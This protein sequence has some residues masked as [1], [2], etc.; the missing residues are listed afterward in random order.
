MSDLIIALLGG[1]A[2]GYLQGKQSFKGWEGFVSK[3]SERLQQLAYNKVFRPVGLYDKVNESAQLYYEAIV[4]YLVGLP[5]ACLPLIFRCLEIGLQKHYEEIE[6]KKCSLN[7]SQL[8]EWSAE[9]LKDKRE[10]AH[11]FR[12][13]RNLIHKEGLIEEQDALE[14]I[15]HITQILNVVFPVR[16]PSEFITGYCPF[17]QHSFVELAERSYCFLGNT[18][19]LQCS[20]CGKNFTQALLPP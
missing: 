1:A 13:L 4:A 15:R 10:V 6:R 14:G 7:S 20:S 11:A 9:A 12:L 8:I 2:F 5:N 3:Y 16:N 19:S 18:F 17:C